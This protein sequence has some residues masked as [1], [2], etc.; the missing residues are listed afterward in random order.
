M[1]A[2]CG[3]GEE[4]LK[5]CADITEDEVRGKGFAHA[6][7]LLRLCGLLCLLFLPCCCFLLPL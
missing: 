4:I 2:G 6:P 3:T 1:Q 7:V 5:A